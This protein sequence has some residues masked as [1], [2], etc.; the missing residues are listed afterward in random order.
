M[1][2]KRAEVDATS[3]V[4]LMLRALHALR[5]LLTLFEARW[6][7]ISREQSFRPVGLVGRGVHVLGEAAQIVALPALRERPIG[8]GDEKSGKVSAGV[9]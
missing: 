5:G 6:R 8:A 4:T 2:T 9:N 3:I 7:C 1:A